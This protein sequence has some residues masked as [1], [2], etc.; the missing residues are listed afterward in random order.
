M[1]VQ[2]VAL[3]AH[4]LQAGLKSWGE[5]A[6]DLAWIGMGVAVVLSSSISLR[7]GAGAYPLTIGVA[8]LILGALNLGRLLLRRM[9]EA[10]TGNSATLD[11]PPIAAD[12]EH[13]VAG[14]QPPFEAATVRVNGA[15]YVLLVA[16]A[17]VALFWLPFLVVAPVIGVGVLKVIF[18]LSWPRASAYS[19]VVAG[20]VYLLFDLIG[21]TPP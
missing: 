21:A 2:L 7:S 9:Q 6:F 11:E 17:V 16:V 1:T 13:L 15:L 14:D 18:H 4:R 5:V 20:I 19:V 10:K 12:S 8:L 3:K